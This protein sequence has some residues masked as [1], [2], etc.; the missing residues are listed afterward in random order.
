[1]A[2]QL[3]LLGFLFGLSTAIYLLSNKRENHRLSRIDEERTPNRRFTPVIL[4]PPP[5]LFDSH[6]Q[7][8]RRE[9][10]RWR[11]H[12]EVRSVTRG[13]RQK[14]S[15]LVDNWQKSILGLIELSKRNLKLANVEYRAK[16]YVGAVQRASASVENIS[17]AL[18]HCFG[19]K[20]DLISG[21]VEALELIVSRFRG[22]KKMK[23]KAAIGDAVLVY[24]AHDAS[25]IVPGTGFST[26][27]QR[28]AKR[29][30]ELSVNI[31]RDFHGLL[32]E[33]FGDE[34]SPKLN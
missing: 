18:I 17:R 23:F 7:F 28:E 1:M 10:P 8:S 32:N 16:N 21:Q 11:L 34:I 15:V 13:P 30:V 6:Q 14:G 12:S 27:I 26:S 4:T 29:A 9:S 19:G 24:Q 25:K 2:M 3:Y 31:V 22:E 5:F 33:K 20:P